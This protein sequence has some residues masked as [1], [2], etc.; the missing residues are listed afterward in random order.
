MFKT[1]VRQVLFIVES[2]LVTRIDGICSMST[3][4]SI[5]IFSFAEHCQQFLQRV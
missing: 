5:V 2:V 3:K 4:Y 1:L